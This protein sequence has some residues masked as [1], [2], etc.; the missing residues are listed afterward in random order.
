[1]YTPVDIDITYHPVCR[2]G[3]T[4]AR[5]IVLLG[6]Q[7]FIHATIRAYKGAPR[8]PGVESLIQ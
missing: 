8:T 3:A 4:V 1:M 5:P 6:K 2:R 7:L